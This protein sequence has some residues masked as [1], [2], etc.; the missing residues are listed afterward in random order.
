MQATNTT[1]IEQSSVR[2]SKMHADS[3][4]LYLK[5]RILLK[6]ILASA[7]GFM[8]ETVGKKIVLRARRNYLGTNLWHSKRSRGLDVF[9]LASPRAFEVDGKAPNFV[10]LPLEEGGSLFVVV[11]SNGRNPEETFRK[12]MTRPI[13]PEWAT[14]IRRYAGYVNNDEALAEPTRRFLRADATL[15]HDEYWGGGTLAKRLPCLLDLVGKAA[16]QSAERELNHFFKLQYEFE[17]Q[18]EQYRFF[19]AYDPVD[20]STDS[21]SDC[22]D[23]LDSLNSP[24][25][26]DSEPEEGTPP[27]PRTTYK[28]RK[29]DSDE[30]DTR[31]ATPRIDHSIFDDEF[32]PV[33]KEADATWPPAELRKNS[34]A[35]S[36]SIE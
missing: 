21:D 12:H 32:E 20:S 19:H 8:P 30:G 16:F 1:E 3:T 25:C 34:L 4:P 35:F 28:K 10:Y 7:H 14:L 9:Y 11:D 27:L 18:L 17:R 31:P 24:D 29:R 33:T 36:T 26:P 6:P 2:T 22:P 23:S 5:H 13:K 15:S